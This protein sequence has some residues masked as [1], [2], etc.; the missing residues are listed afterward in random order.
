MKVLSNTKPGTTKAGASSKASYV[1]E[2]GIAD[3]VRA[4]SAEM[5]DKHPLYPGLELA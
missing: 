1:M 4:E 3:R 5:L 2:P